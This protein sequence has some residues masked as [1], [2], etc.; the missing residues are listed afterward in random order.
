MPRPSVLDPCV[1]L[2]FTRLPIQLGC[3]FCSCGRNHGMTHV[4]PPDYCFSS[5]GN[6]HLYGAGEPAPRMSSLSHI[7][8]MNGFVFLKL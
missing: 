3:T 5:C 4:E 1:K 6:F 2:R 8:H 7:W